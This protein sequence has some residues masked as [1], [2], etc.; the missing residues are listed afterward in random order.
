MTGIL[1]GLVLVL[2]Q[3]REEENKENKSSDMSVRLPISPHATTLLL[4][5]RHFMK[6]DIPVFFENPP[7][8]F[9]V[10]LKKGVKCTLVQALR[11]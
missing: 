8:K 5:G 1:P 11:E 2:S 9:K 10:S 3:D 7:R 4:L 6:I